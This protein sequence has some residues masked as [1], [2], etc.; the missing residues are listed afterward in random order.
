MDNKPPTFEELLPDIESQ[1]D[2]RRGSWRL[3]SVPW[4]D[5]KQQ[6]LAKVFFKFHTFD[7]EKGKF[8][9]WLSRVITRAMINILRDNHTK[10]SRPCVTGCVFNTGNDT[11]SKTK[12]GIQ[13][14]ECIIYKRWEER[15]LN[16]YRVQQTLPLDNHTQEVHA[17]QS[18]FIDI[19]A[20]K[21]VIDEKM[22]EKLDTY[23]YNIYK[24]IY[25]EGKTEKEVGKLLGYKKTGKMFSGYQQLL[26]I[27]KLIIL[28]AKEI[29]EEQGLA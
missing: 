6:I 28:K 9:H 3:A 24:L 27:R 25:I 4:D 7:P 23:E 12:S 8:S 20:S 18:D 5:V 10:F 17:I 14:S 13:C 21:V 19:E 29:I 26:K 2:T 22:K 1:I 16:H 15:K 11:C